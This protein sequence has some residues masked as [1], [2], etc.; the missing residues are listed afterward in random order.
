MED[1]EMIQV[2]SSNIQAIGYREDIQ[3]L[4]VQFLN[5]RIYEY[6][7]FPIM[8]FEQFRSAPSLGSYLNYNIKGKYPTT[9]IQ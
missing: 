1:F 8:E 3:T 6:L 4:R 9:R 2:S 7:N 5:G